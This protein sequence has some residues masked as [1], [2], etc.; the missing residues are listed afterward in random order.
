LI[1]I[2]V[3]QVYQQIIIINSYTQ[4]NVSYFENLISNDPVTY[5][6]YLKHFNINFHGDFTFYKKII[7]NLLGLLNEKNKIIIID[8]VLGYIKQV[9]EQIIKNL[10]NK[11]HN[12]NNLFI[13]ERRSNN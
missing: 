7:I 1:S 3:K 6:Q 12:E 5:S 11:I 2:D 9:D 8:D 13:T 4:P 10:L